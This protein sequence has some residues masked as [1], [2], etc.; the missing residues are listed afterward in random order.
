M[1]NKINIF[2][3]NGSG[4]EYA[5]LEKILQNNSF[6]TE[7]K[8]NLNSDEMGFDFADLVILLPVVYPFVVELR[9][10]LCS[11]LSYK[12]TQT[13]EFKLTLENNGKKLHMEAKNMNIPNIDEF[14][15]FFGIED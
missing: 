14:N 10:T 5:E 1:E 8:S 15:S 12:K 2:I 6:K 11:Y 3:E 4:S 7:R 13:P 9:K